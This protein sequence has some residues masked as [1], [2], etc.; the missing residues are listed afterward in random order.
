MAV[1][2]LFGALALVAPLAAST[3]SPAS[4]G[5][6]L[7]ILLDNNL[8]GK[9]RQHPHVTTSPK[10]TRVSQEPAVPRQTRE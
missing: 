4:I 10:L 3:P 7:T 6:G 1:R 8:Q 2:N 9:P 5:S